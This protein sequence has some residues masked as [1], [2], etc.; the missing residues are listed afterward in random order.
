MFLCQAAFAVEVVLEERDVWLRGVLGGEELLVC[1]LG[2]C[3]RLN[4]LDDSLH[5]R[6]RSS[7]ILDV[8]CEVDVRY[9]DIRLSG[10]ITRDTA[11][12]YVLYDRSRRHGPCKLEAYLLRHPQADPT[13]SGQMD[14]PPTLFL[15][16]AIAAVCLAWRV[17]ASCGIIERTIPISASALAHPRGT[18]GTLRRRRRRY[19]LL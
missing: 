3:R 18:P 12:A 8:L 6:H 9:L 11:L 14:W 1:R 17:A 7:V 19:A 10:Q 13:W 15:I 5:G 16:C 2:E 4:V